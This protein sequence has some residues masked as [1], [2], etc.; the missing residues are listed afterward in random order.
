M[1]WLNFD[2]LSQLAF[3]YFN[4]AERSGYS[5]TAIFSKEKSEI[6]SA[7]GDQSA[8]KIVPRGT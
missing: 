4:A 6:V 7:D 3:T 5:G 2:F 1:P 8:A